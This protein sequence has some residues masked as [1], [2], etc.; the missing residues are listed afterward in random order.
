PKRSQCLQRRETLI[1]VRRSVL[2]GNR[3]RASKSRRF[4]HEG[5]VAAKLALH[6]RLN[7]LGSES[8][9]NR[10]F[11]SRAS[12]FPPFDFQSRAAPFQS[13]AN[14]QRTRGPRKRA[15][16]RGIRSELVEC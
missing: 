6:Y 3:D 10:R 8:V 5:Y 12:A 1:S 4:P 9:L 2:H 15:V 11:H 14:V 16:L 7:Q 13:P